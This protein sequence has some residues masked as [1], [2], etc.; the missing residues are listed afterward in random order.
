MCFALSHAYF[1]RVCGEVEVLLHAFLT[2]DGGGWRVSSHNH[3]TVEKEAVCT[4]EPVWM[5]GEMKN[6]LPLLGFGRLWASLIL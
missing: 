6:F 2:L 1:M 4:P 5:F 3:C